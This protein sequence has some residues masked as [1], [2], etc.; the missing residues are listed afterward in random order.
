MLKKTIIE[1]FLEI[2]KKYSTKIALVVRNKNYSYE[3]LKEK[4][5]L[6]ASNIKF[7]AKKDQVIGIFLDRSFLQIASILGCLICN[8]SFI[9]FDSKIPEKKIKFIIRKLNIRT[10]IYDGPK[11]TFD[12]KLKYLR[13]KQILSQRKNISFLDQEYNSE[14]NVYYIFTSGS[15][16]EPKGVQI[17]NTNLVTFVRNCKKIFKINNTDRVILL[18]YLSFDLSVFPLWVSLCSGSTIYYPIG[19]DIIYP[20]HFI[21]KNNI[22]V[23]CSVPSQI[24]I[25][26]EFLKNTNV[27]LDSVKLS[28]FCGEPLTYSQV[29]EMRNY[30]KN[31]KIFN[32]YG[33]SETT[34]FNT[35][36]RVNKIPSNRMS[37]I[38]SIG[39]EMPGNKI[40]LKNNEIIISGKQVSNGYIDKKIN[41][42]NFFKKGKYYHYKTGDYAKKIK[43]NFYFIGRKDQQIKLSGYRIELGDIERNISKVIKNKR[44]VIL[45][46][47]K[48]ILAILESS[49]KLSKNELFEIKKKIPTYAIPKNFYYLRKFPLNK[50]MKIDKMKIKKIIL[51]EYKSNN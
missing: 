20:V 33:P 39:K 9:I 30:F 13:T 49:R 16:G 34:C 17:N 48:N 23:Y 4:S 43:K 42:N 12:K 19:V 2:S 8:K 29:Y 40:T 18:P 38:I 46:E 41:K 51:N 47:N 25:I 10:I 21:K 24:S 36:Y 22:T 28:V 3:E 14:N 35:Y 5:F 6:I 27:K 50:N 7:Y 45:Y 11:S 26:N 15:T 37:D 44:V 31:T 1:N 32:T